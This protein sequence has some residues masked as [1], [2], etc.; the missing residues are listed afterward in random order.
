MTPTSQ[1]C[2]HG[3]CLFCRFSWERDLKSSQDQFAKVEFEASFMSERAS[4]FLSPI[5]LCGEYCPTS[6]KK[7]SRTWCGCMHLEPVV[8]HPSHCQHCKFM[9]PYP[10]TAQRTVAFAACS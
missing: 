1:I 8:R 7:H 2:V 4:V 9:R 10:L 6:R 5:G 3:V